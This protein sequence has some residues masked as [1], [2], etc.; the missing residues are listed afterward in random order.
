MGL[1]MITLSGESFASRMA[2]RLLEAIG[3]SAGITETLGGYI[4]TAV[5]L[6]TNPVL[7]SNYRSVFTEANWAATIGDIAT[8]TYHYEQTLM[9][10]TLGH[11]GETT[12]ESET[13]AEAF[14]DR[15]LAE[16]V[17]A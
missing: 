2:G 10:I 3:A 8:F 5:M 6:A 16:T 12:R 17:A 13:I 11:P 4:E 14:P 1:P 9:Q 7:L 15:V